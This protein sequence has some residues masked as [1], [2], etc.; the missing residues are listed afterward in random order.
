VF[1]LKLTAGK[2]VSS[3]F[4]MASRQRRRPPPRRRAP[5]PGVR[6][7]RGAQQR[8]TSNRRG[9]KTPTLIGGEGR[10]GW[11]LGFPLLVRCVPLPCKKNTF[12]PPNR[13][14]RGRA[15]RIGP[16]PS[17]TPCPVRDGSLDPVHHP[18][19]GSPRSTSTRNGSKGAR[20]VTSPQP[21]AGSGVGPTSPGPPLVARAVQ[22]PQPPHQPASRLFYPDY[23]GS[24]LLV[25]VGWA[26]RDGAGLRI[27]G[28][29][30]SDG[31]G[32]RSGF[33]A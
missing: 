9:R 7:R 30:G 23:T 26:R 17:R 18:R 29:D 21:K 11:G 22:A 6:S 25:W 24:H 13:S 16:K 1:H 12:P 4:L 14:I 20:T 10:L 28:R 3:L 8:G 32:A 5:L 27:D 15:A 33:W 2:R 31:R 19:G